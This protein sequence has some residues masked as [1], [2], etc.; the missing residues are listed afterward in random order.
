M[1]KKFTWELWWTDLLK[2][3]P[4]LFATGFMIAKEPSFGIP[5]GILAAYVGYLYDLKWQRKIDFN[6]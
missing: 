6:G 1:K 2:F 5:F 3:T 4:L